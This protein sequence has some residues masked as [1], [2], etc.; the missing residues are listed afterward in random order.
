MTLEFED[1]NTDMIM[2]IYSL[3][4]IV[5]AAVVLLLTL[6]PDKNERIKP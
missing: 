3:S 1:F 4:V 2:N 5:C 6:K